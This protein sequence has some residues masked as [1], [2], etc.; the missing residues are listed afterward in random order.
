M[1]NDWVPAPTIQPEVT[2]QPRR[3]RK[4]L[5]GSQHPGWHAF[6]PGVSS[7]LHR[8]R[9]S[10]SARCPCAWSHTQVSAWQRPGNF[11]LRQ[12]SNNR[13]GRYIL[14]LKWDQPSSSLHL[15]KDAFQRLYRP[16]RDCCHRM[17]GRNTLCPLSP[18]HQQH[19]TGI[20]PL[21]IC[22]EGKNGN[23]NHQDS[24]AQTSKKKKKSSY[25]SHLLRENLTLP[26]LHNA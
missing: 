19:W 9:H 20:R 2:Q 23:S 1:G 15:N 16:H 26:F 5:E 18:V 14:C 17:G 24:L 21:S 4:Q 11:W 8:D 13:F 3:A 7:H 12:P 22:Q 25:C 10:R 6:P